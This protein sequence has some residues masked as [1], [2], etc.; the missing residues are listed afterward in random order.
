MTAQPATARPLPQELLRTMS[1]AI[2]REAYGKGMSLTAHLNRMYPESEFKDGLDGFARLLQAADIKTRSNPSEGYFADRWEKFHVS[3]ET[4]ALVPEWVARQWRQVTHGDVRAFYSDQED[5]PGSM[6]RPFKD[7]MRPR[8]DKQ[9]APS[10]PVSELVAMTSPIDGDTYRTYYLTDSPANQRKVRVGSGDDIP[11]AK[12][13]AAQHTIPLYK[14]GR[15]LEAS[16]EQL[17]RQR[18]DRIALH[19]KRMAVQT[20]IDKVATVLDVVVNGDGNA[21]TAATSFNL[22][23]L[24]AGTTAN[25]VTLLAWLAFKMKFAAPYVLNTALA[26]DAI[27]LKLLMLNMGSAN[28]PLVTI[29]GPAM[30]GYFRQINPGLSDNVGLGWTADAPASKV[31]AMDNRFAVERVTEIGSDIQ[32]IERYAHRQ[33]QAIFMTEVEGYG[34]IDANASKILVVNA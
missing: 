16:Y 17:R 15:G 19:I 11:K 9:I 34:I 14:Y 22:T 27:A 12:L 20:E 4:R 5:I 6:A 24:D 13:V 10:I 18:I 33:T 23:A 2:Y 8:A 7:S 3:D 29:A 21:N 31:V 28:V 26:Q 30:M 25:N 32:E 1:P